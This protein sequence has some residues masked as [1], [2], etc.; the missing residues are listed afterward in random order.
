MVDSNRVHTKNLNKQNYNFLFLI[1]IFIALFGSVFLAMLKVDVGY[2]YTLLMLFAISSIFLVTLF[3]KNDDTLAPI[4]DYARVPIAVNNTLAVVMYFLGMGLPFLLNFIVKTASSFQ[5]VA[6]PLFSSDIV[7]GQSFT[8]ASIGG[9]MAWRIFNVMFVAGNVETFVYNFGLVFVFVL[10][11]WAILMFANGGKDL[12]FMKKKTFILGFAMV[13]SMIAF[14]ISHQ[15][16]NSYTGIAFLVAGIFLL[17]ANLSIYVAGFFLSFWAGY[18]QSNNLL[19]L[20]Q[21][22]GLR[23]VSNGF[24]SWFGLI[25]LAYIGLLIY[26]LLLNTKKAGKVTKKWARS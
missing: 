18:H 14:V 8:T 2:I 10:I 6:T 9:S 15:L 1:N 23:A 7:G 5:I 26:H 13:M 11:G 20:I 21:T 12:P 19:F 4:T 24:V 22:E 25:F 3:L 17:I 16:N